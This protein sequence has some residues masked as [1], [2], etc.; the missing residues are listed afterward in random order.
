MGYFF[1][2]KQYFLLYYFDFPYYNQFGFSYNQLSFN[3]G[4]HITT[5]YTD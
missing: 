1:T 3:M 2:T 4:S 5:T